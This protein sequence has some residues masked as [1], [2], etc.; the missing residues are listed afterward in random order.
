MDFAGFRVTK[1]AFAMEP[2]TDP[3]LGLGLDEHAE[4]WTEH[5][6]RR[7]LEKLP[8]GAYMCDAQGLIT[9]FNER[10]VEVWGRKPRLREPEE[11]FCG[12]FRMFHGDG[13]SM[14][15]AECWMALALRDR[16]EYSGKEVV[17]ERPDGQRM[18]ALAHA[19]PICDESGNLF[20]AVN[21]LIDITDRKRA[22]EALRRADRAKDEFLATLAHELRS[23]LAPIR[24]AVEILHVQGPRDSQSNWAL[25]VIGRQMRHLS[26]L[27]DDLMD[28]A[29]VTSNRLEL[30]RRRV[31]LAE[32][33][34]SAVETSQPLLQASGH[35]F[36]ALLPPEPV[37]VHA[38]AVRLSQALSN[39]LNNAAR[40]THPGGRIRLT[41][42]REG[43]EAVVRVS[44]DGIGIAP[45]VLP[46]VF[47]MF[48]QAARSEG[49]SEGGLG[50]GLTL[51]ERLVE[52]HGGTVRAESG[53]LGRG[54]VFT[55]RLPLDDS[56]QAPADEDGGGIAAPAASLRILVVDDNR[57]SV[58]S[59]G[60]LLR[61]LGHE[62]FTAHDGPA[63]L[64]AAE[65]HRPDAVVLDI[66]LPLMDGHEVARRIREQPW[67][68][69]M[70][71]IAVTGWAQDEDRERSMQV[72]FDHHMAKPVDPAV[73]LELLARSG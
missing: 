6:F 17:I 48:M 69:T 45:E 73:L 37:W 25:D 36:A 40:Y 61:L 71:L 39:L 15:H 49:G 12:S 55:V 50:I 38:D 5:Q 10:A 58:E 19:N 62:V 21:V 57:D 42:E 14:P 53:G 20:G 47:D 32:V 3:K 26:R 41:V 46:R 13:R 31:P 70:G 22:E 33:V 16:T 30:R 9:Y 54:S 44:D 65:T 24:N 56:T 29:R 67:G 34:R 68:R 23:P 35:D 2:K 7:L 27:I 72:G 52:M 1:V 66:G 64:A 43:G 59:L 51:V 28:L 60:V 11:R 18:T 63:A 4:L 8:A